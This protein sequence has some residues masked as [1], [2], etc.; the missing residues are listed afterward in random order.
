LPDLDFGPGYRLHR[1]LQAERAARRRDQQRRHVAKQAKEPAQAEV[2]SAD[3]VPT[4]LVSAAQPISA[5]PAPVEPVAA[6]PVPTEPAI[7][8]PVK[9]SLPPR[10]E[11]PAQRVARMIAADAARAAAEKA[12]AA[13]QAMAAKTRSAEPARGGHAERPSHPHRLA[14]PPRSRADH[15]PG[16][17]RFPF[18][19]ARGSGR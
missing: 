3:P 11:T 7:A 17:H 5:E 9:E 14:E 18:G 15:R 16:R 2:L 19:T 12:A 10:D 13:Q 8:E 6:A 4:E 1:A